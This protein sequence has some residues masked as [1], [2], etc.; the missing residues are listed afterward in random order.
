MSDLIH[1]RRLV[2]RHQSGLPVLGSASMQIPALKGP[3]AIDQRVALENPAPCIG[4]PTDFVKPTT[5]TS[6]T[7]RAHDGLAPAGRWNL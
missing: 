1:Q 4:T 2:M 7:T 3:L 5:Q 6:P